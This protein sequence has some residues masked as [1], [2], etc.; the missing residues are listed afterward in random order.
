M[1]SGSLS[2]FGG[3]L[4]L[5]VV[6]VGCSNDNDEAQ[7]ME[8]YFSTGGPQW[9]NQTGWSS[10]AMGAAP[11]AAKDMGSPPEWC[12]WKGVECQAAASDGTF[13]LVSLSLP[14]NNL[15]GT[16]PNKLFCREGSVFSTLRSF[17]VSG[18]S[19]RGSLFFLE[20]DDAVCFRSKAPILRALI[21]ID[22]SR[23]L[24]NASVDG[25][26]IM[27]MPQI[28]FLMMRHNRL[29]GVMLDPT[30]RH[31]TTTFGVESGMSFPHLEILDIGYNRLLGLFPTE[32][33]A[34]NAPH[35][36]ELWLDNN[37]I[38]DQTLSWLSVGTV[39]GVGNGIGWRHTL[40]VLHLE[41][42]YIQASIPNS[43]G[44]FTNLKELSLDGN[45][46][47]GT[48]PR[49]IRQLRLLTHLSLAHNYL[50]GSIPCN[51]EGSGWFSEHSP[52]VDLKFFDVTD[53]DLDGEVCPVSEGHSLQYLRLA[54]NN[55]R[56]VVPPLN[57]SKLVEVTLG[58]ENRWECELPT[59]F[60]IPSWIDGPPSTK[61]YT[62]VPMGNSAESTS[63]GKAAQDK[64]TSRISDGGVV[65]RILRG[66]G[67]FFGSAESDTASRRRGSRS[68]GHGTALGRTG[69]VVF[70]AVL[71]LLIVTPISVAVLSAAGVHLPSAA[72]CLLPSW[73]AKL[74][75][76]DELQ[77]MSD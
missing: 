4:M 5:C 33:L 6:I 67:F 1:S 47:Y 14:H 45:R 58:G 26:L 50:R 13:T 48:I 22:V 59:R 51:Q 25:F 7:L 74:V 77:T 43:V 60:D 65:A 70:S 54:D 61:C 40:A 69:V 68:Q 46:I 29:T 38:V 41:N 15:Q 17:N 63:G 10:R 19:I 23:N 76:M 66:D 31:T 2:T 3:I 42:N 52:F 20:S 72:A 30:N 34:L 62:T 53:N 9:T 39:E 12:Q 11:L 18:N 75:E 37:F 8:F 57:G 21:T 28:R 16:L 55:L 44:R 49:D 32:A 36:R 27:K 24:F 35:L 71:V 73:L 56:G 64:Q